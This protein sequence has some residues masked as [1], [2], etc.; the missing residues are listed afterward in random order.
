MSPDTA[1]ADEPPRAAWTELPTEAATSCD[2]AGLATTRD[3]TPTSSAP[4]CAPGA[5]LPII[6]VTLVAIVLRSSSA[7]C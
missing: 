5:W 7:P 6:V 2:P 3:P 4:T 1:D